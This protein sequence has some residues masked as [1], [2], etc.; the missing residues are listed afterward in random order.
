MIWLGCL[1]PSAFGQAKPLTLNYSTHMPAQHG[2]TLNAIDWG[3]EIE[4]RTQG[5]VK[6][7]VMAGSTMLGADKCYDGVVKGIA[8][9]GLAVPGFTRGRFPLSEVLD[10]PLG[11]KSATA[12]TRLANLYYRKFMPKEFAESRVMYIFA[13]GPGVLHSKKIVN[14]LA[15]VKGMKIRCTGLSAKVVSAIG[16]APVAMPVGE[17]Y[18]ALSRGVVDASFASVE[19]AS[20]WKLAEVTKY[21]IES[22]AIGYT[23]SF[24]VVMNKRV[25]DSLGP[26][27]QKIVEKV[28]EEWI[29]LEANGWEKMEKHGRDFALKMNNKMISF[30]KEDDEKIAQ[31]M[32][33]LLDEYVA[34]AKKSGLPGEEVLKYCLDQLKALQ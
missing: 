24:F 20:A 27:T 25:W 12:A 33:P 32:K 21:I 1:N 16:A 11:Y 31:A 23:T 8:D 19:A 9:A 34:N 26:E 30:S 13:H 22:P 14:T 15:D 10:L 7:T 2:V 18:D 5:K 29:E 4:K 3:K 28:N 17:A 6:F